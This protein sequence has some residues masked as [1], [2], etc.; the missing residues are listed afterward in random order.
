[1]K[2]SVRTFLYFDSLKHYEEKTFNETKGPFNIFTPE[3]HCHIILRFISVAGV[4]PGFK[5]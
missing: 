4:L 3:T 5:K 2:Y 1:M